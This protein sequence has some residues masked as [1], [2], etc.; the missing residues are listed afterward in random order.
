MNSKSF[1]KYEEKVNIK[2]KDE[3]LKSN[4]YLNLSSINKSSLKLTFLKKV[5]SL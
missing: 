4:D 3:I 1:D 2:A 5:L